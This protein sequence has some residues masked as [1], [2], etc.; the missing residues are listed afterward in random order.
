LDLL[1]IEEVE[2]FLADPCLGEGQDRKSQL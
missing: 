2:D 1:D